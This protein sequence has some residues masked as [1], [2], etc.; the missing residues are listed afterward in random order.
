LLLLPGLA[1]AAPLLL[2]QDLLLPAAAAGALLLLLRL[3][4]G[5][6]QLPAPQQPLQ[7]RLAACWPSAAAQQ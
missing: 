4:V 7:Q 1:A 2:V 3:V 6:S 5:P